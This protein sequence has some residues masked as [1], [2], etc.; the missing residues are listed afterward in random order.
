MGP[1]RKRDLA[2]AVVAAAVVGYVVVRSLYRYFPAITLWTGLSLL[3]LAG[4]EAVW[5]MSVR[6]RIRD[7]R[8]G[9]GAGRLHPLAVAR[10]VAVAKASAWVGAVMLGWWTGVLVYLVPRRGELR[11]AAV[12]TPGVATSAISAFA[13]VVA[14]LWLQHCCTSPGEPGAS[15]VSAGSVGSD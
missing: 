10:T 4:G 8:I 11:V 1:T 15:D 2:A 3:A 5:A 7:G 13:L 14:A 9:V 12:D 6:N